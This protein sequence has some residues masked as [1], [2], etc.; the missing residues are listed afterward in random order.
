MPYVGADGGGTLPG[1]CWVFPKSVG[2][3]Q[4]EIS[5]EEERSWQVGTF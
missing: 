5:P 2:M 1:L 3:L 4:A